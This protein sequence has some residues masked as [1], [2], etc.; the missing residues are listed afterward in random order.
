MK[1]LNCKNCFVIFIIIASFGCVNLVNANTATTTEDFRGRIVLQSAHYNDVWYVHPKTLRRYY[2]PHKWELDTLMRTLGV[3]ILTKDL[4]KIAIPWS[5][6]SSDPAALKRFSGHIVL[7]VQSKGEAWYINP[8]DGFRYYLPNNEEGLNI[9]RSLGVGASNN[10]LR[11]IAMNAT[12]LYATFT[13]TAYAHVKLDAGKFS[14]AYYADNILP[15]ASLTKLMTALVILDSK[16]DWEKKIILTQE[17][18]QYPKIY[19]DPDD[20][21]SEVD[22]QEGAAITYQDLWNALLASSSNQAAGILAKNSGFTYKEFIKKM[23]DKAKSMGLKK[24]RFTDPSGLDTLNVGTAKEMAIIARA[25]F[26]VSKIK[27]TTIKSF[28]IRALRP[29]DTTRTIAVINRNQSILKFGPDAAK[30]GFLYEAQRNVAYQEG[31]AV[32]VILHAR[33]LT[34]KNTLIKKLLK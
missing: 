6:K 4:E 28:I 23:N 22:F 29:D 2:I 18:I 1:Y 10:E 24:T 33:T 8:N 5:G 12:Q 32:V 27:T 3:G 34:E 14:Q 16:P 15:L 9:L 20:V 21:T 11:M 17:D 25:A 30:S 26:N 31:S 13:F 19:V 7:Q